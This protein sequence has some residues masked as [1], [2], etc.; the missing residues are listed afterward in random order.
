MQVSIVD[1]WGFTGLK[2]KI[3]QF[4]YHERNLLVNGCYERVDEG[5]HVL[6]ISR[7]KKSIACKILCSEDRL[8]PRFK[9]L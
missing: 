2:V 9:P 6:S 8:C 3:I 7:A 4:T 5:I 1:Q